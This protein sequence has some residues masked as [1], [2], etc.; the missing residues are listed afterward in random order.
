MDGERPLR[1]LFV[2]D[3]PSDVELAKH[4]LLREGIRFTAKTVYTQETLLDALPSFHPDLVISDYAMPRFDGMRALRLCREHDPYLPVIILTGSMNEETAVACMKAGA[5]DY[6]IKEQIERLPLAVCRALEWKADRLEREQAEQAL[7]ESERRFRAI[8]DNVNDAVFIHEVDANGMPGRFLEVN[9]V[10]CQRLG[11]TRE[12]MLTMSPQDIDV[13][14]QRE[15]PPAIMEKLL[16]TGEARFETEHV[17][18]QGERIPVEISTR[19]FDLS[20]QRVVLSVARDVSERKRLE[21]QFYQAQKMESIG[22]LAGGIAHDFNNLLTVINGYASMLLRG[23]SPNDPVYDGLRQIL[24][25]GQRAARLTG[26]LLAFSRKQVLNPEVLDLNQVLAEIEKML[27]R[28][29]GEDVELV[30]LLGEG[31]PNV[32]ADRGQLEQVIV[33]LAVNARD[34]MPEGGR[35]TIETRR[36]HLDEDYARQYADVRPGDYVLIAVSDTGIGMDQEVLN[37]LFEPFFTTKEPGKGTGLGL[38]TVY[39]IVKQSG[40]HITVYSEVGLGSTFRIYLPAVHETTAAPPRDTERVE[41][42]G[43][44]ETILVV[45]DEEMVRGLACRALRDRGYHV[46]EASNGG[47]ALLICKRQRQPIDLILTDMIMPQMS[48]KELVER[49]RREHP[50]MKA[51]YMSGYSDNALVRRIQTAAEG[52]ARF[53]Q[54]PFSLATLLREVRKALDER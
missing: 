14:S 30:L 2:E 20:G 50:G 31:V 24:D 34:A 35:L 36:V 46:L 38:A 8:F 54:K 4:E 44:R 12:E 33:N 23:F 1:I 5:I 19:L 52:G 22:R 27:K 29:I 32:R 16:R 3:L 53:I 6:V 21:Q 45:E 47:E 17:T 25:A 40:G 48:G 41:T 28:M 51:L 26:Q 42:L 10:A 37:R 18:R 39:G 49:L 7:R 43:G 9:R 11:Y 15:Q 13:P